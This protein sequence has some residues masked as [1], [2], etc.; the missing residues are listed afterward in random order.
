MLVTSVEIETFRNITNKAA[1]RLGIAQSTISSKLSILDLDLEL[2]ADLVEGRRTVEHV[3]NL[4]KLPPRNSGRSRT[5]PAGEWPP[6]RC[7]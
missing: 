5:R 6:K 3:R 1:K 4:S 2:Q 7:H